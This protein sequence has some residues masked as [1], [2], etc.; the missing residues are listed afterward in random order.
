MAGGFGTQ[1]DVMAGVAGRLESINGELQ[2]QLRS[3]QGRLE[4]L[5]ADWQ[6][7]GSNAFQGTMVRWQTDAKRI[8]DALLGIAER[9]RAGAGRYAANEAEAASMLGVLG[10]GGGAGGGAV[11]GPGAGTITNALG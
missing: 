11:G 6:G 3:L 7:Q 1:T 10:D 4:P 8:N 2:G 5:V 9:V